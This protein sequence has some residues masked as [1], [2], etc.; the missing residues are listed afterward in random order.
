MAA[1]EP[2]QPPDDLAEGASGEPDDPEEAE[3]KPQLAQRIASLVIGTLLALLVGEVAVRIVVTQTLIYNIEMVRY[4][5]ELKTPDPLGEVSHVHRQNASAHL[6]GV[7]ITLNSL[8][9]RGPDLPPKS[10]DRKRVFVLGSSVTMGWG[11]PVDAMFTS[12]AE[13]RFNKDLPLGPATHVEIANAGIGNY[14][15]LAQ[16]RLFAHQYGGLKPDLVVL[17]Y[18]IS[19]PEP[20]PP[21]KNSVILR[22]S[23]FAAYCYDRFRTLGL[24]AEGKN[25]L[26]K[27]YSEIYDD[28][29]PYWNDTLAKISEMRDVAAK[30]GVPFVVMIIPDFH[31]L[32][33]GT[34]YGPLYEKMEKGFSARGIHVFNSF[35]EFQK[36]YGG[37]ETALWI[38]QDDPHPNATGHALMAELLYAELAKP[39]AF[40]LENLPSQ[41]TGP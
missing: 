12:L 5:K 13:Q 31:N 29:Q 24:A 10:A 35:P 28:A 23:L 11:V 32:R 33:P 37:Q 3:K 19:D 36:R 1:A 8:G 39:G 22:H 7:D 6:M 14:N 21:G 25:D 17:H 30:N 4:A 41:P 9:H 38:Q 15:T 20:R 2:S 27:H 18:F 34:P 26:F 16:S 40:V